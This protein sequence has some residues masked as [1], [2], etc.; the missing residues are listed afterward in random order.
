MDGRAETAMTGLEKLRA[1]DA[2]A[3]IERDFF[4]TGS[5]AEVLSGLTESVDGIAIEAYRTAIEPVLPQGAAMLA[6][7]SFG[8]QEL[9]PYSDVDILIL[10]EADSPWVALREV[11]SEFVRLLWDAGLRLNHTVRTL[12]ECLGSQEQNVEFGISLLD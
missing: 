9:F 11:L 1:G 3:R 12:D 4:A 2:W 6:L 5:A 10:L 8:R 7:G